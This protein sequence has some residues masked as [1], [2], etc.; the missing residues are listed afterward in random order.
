M[1]GRQEA[2]QQAAS[3]RGLEISCVKNGP[4]Q[5]VRFLVFSSQSYPRG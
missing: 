3:Y 4:D 5:D 1:T 2:A